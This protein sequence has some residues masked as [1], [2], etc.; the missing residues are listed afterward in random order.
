MRTIKKTLLDRMVAQA[1]EA[2]VQGF[3]KT[4]ELLTSQVE[5][6]THLV[7]KTGSFYIYSSDDFKNEVQEQFW[8]AIVR[9]ADFHDTSFDANEIQGIVEKSAEE[10]IKEVRTKLG[11]KTPVG[12]YEPD[13]PGES[14]EKVT[15]E[16]E[17]V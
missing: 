16:V 12:A 13:L 7:R 17:E 5:K 10:F 15:I 8:N 6:N 9:I 3:S 2:E 1:E 4:A 14:K 11:I